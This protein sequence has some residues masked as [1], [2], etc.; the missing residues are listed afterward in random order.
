[1]LGITFATHLK[2]V[3]CQMYEVVFVTEVELTRA[4]SQI[5]LLVDIYFEVASDQGPD[6]KIELAAI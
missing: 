4:S 5:S 1:M 2:T 6:P 3:I